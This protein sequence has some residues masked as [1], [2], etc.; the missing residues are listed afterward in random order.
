M[1]WHV[2]DW[3]QIEDSPES[4]S[5]IAS[6]RDKNTQNIS[7]SVFQTVNH[8]LCFHTC[9]DFNTKMWMQIACLQCMTFRP[10]TRHSAFWPSLDSLMRP[11]HK[12]GR[13][14]QYLLS[15]SARIY[16]TRSW[17]RYSGSLATPQQVTIQ[18]ASEEKGGG[19][20][21]TVKK[22]EEGWMIRVMC[23]FLPG[24]SEM[25]ILY[26]ACKTSGLIMQE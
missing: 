17:G 14:A 21:D 8:M 24:H 11:Q 22:S 18:Q 26:K 16:G 5:R 6:W 12:T 10:H 23:R 20:R 7:V 15:S 25:K 4:L 9:F 3:E 2:T 1:W 19:G 13:S